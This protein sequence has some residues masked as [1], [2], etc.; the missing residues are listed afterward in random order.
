MIIHFCGDFPDSY[1]EF[2]EITLVCQSQGIH[3][4]FLLSQNLDKISE[5]NRGIVTQTWEQCSQIVRLFIPVEWSYFIYELFLSIWH[6]APKTK[7]SV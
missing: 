1:C 5:G 4:V 7:K 6:S 2:K 3:E